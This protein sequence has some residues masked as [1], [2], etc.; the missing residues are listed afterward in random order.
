[1]APEELHV[2]AQPVVFGD[3]HVKVDHVFAICHHQRVAAGAAIKLPTTLV[4]EAERLRAHEGADRLDSLARAEDAGRAGIEDLVAQQPI[5]DERA[6]GISGEDAARGAVTG[7]IGIIDEIVGLVKAR[8]A[9]VPAE[10]TVRR[11]TADFDRSLVVKRRRAD[12]ESRG[13]EARIGAGLDNFIDEAGGPGRRDAR[14]SPD[15]I[16]L[17]LLQPYRRL[18]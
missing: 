7:A 2:V 17:E 15:G 10:G 3:A 12:A 18:C 14:W 11:R 4:G 13:R 6:V 1:S 16:D 9:D 5:T 8:E